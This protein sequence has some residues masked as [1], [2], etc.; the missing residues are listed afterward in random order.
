MPTDHR[1]ALA[2]IR[3]FPQLIA[4]LRDEMGWP[5]KQDSFDE[6]DE[7]F[8]EYT[9]EELGI[10]VQNAA[11]I[12]EIK[13][14]RPLSTHQPWGVFFV[15]FEPKRL[16]VVALRRILSRVALKKRAS[17]NSAERAAWSTD[18]LLFISNY[19]EGESRQICF[20]HFSQNEEKQDLPILKVLGWDNLDSP[21]HL[22]HVAELLTN[23]LSW[24]DDEENESGWR[25]QWHSAFTLVHREVINTSKALSVELA[26]LARN[27]RNSI[28]TV[29]S[30]ESENGPVSKLMAAF[31]EALVHDLDEDGFA[32]MYAQTIAYGLLSARIANPSGDTSDALATAMPVTNPFLKELMAT[33]LEVGGRKGKAGPGPGIDF[34]ELGVSDVI[35]LLD[36]ANMEAVLRDFGDRTPQEDPVIHFFEGFLRE[37]DKKIRKDRGVFYTPRPVVSFIVHSVDELLR[38]EFGLE[39]GLADTTTWGEMAGRI[40]DLEIPEGATATQAFVQVLDP[41][42]G[43]GTFLVEVID[44]IHKTMTVKWQDERQGKKMM[45]KLWN[46]YV[47]KHLLPRLHGYELMMAPYT[48]AHMKIGLKLYETGY[49]FESD[50]RARVYL[51]NALEPAQDFSGRLAFAI[52]ALA[53]EAKAVNAI[54]R[55]QRFTVVIGNPPYSIRSSNL[56]SQ[57]RSLVE[58]FKEIGGAGIR[59]KGAL[60]LEKNLN[61][62]Y[63]K[64]FGLALQLLCEGSL[65]IVSF[66]SNHGFIDNRTFRGFRWNL[67]NNFSR[68]QIVDLHG[69]SKRREMVPAG[70]MNE[71]VFDIQQGV[72][73]SALV[74]TGPG[75]S[76]GCAEIRN[77]WGTRTEKYESLLSKGAN[78]EMAS[79]VEP[80]FS[81]EIVDEALRAEFLKFDSLGE[82]MPVNSTGIKT[83]R[84]AFVIDFDRE[85]LRRRIEEFRGKATDKDIADE[86]GLKDTY[87]WKLSKSR[88]R[89]RTRTDWKQNFQLCLYRPFDHR[90]IYYSSD[91]V[92]LPRSECMRHLAGGANLALLATRQVTSSQFTHALASRLVSEMKTCSHDRGTNCFPLYLQATEGE[93]YASPEPNFSVEFLG[94]LAVT[95]ELESPSSGNITEGVSAVQ[96]FQYIYAVLYSPSYRTR[97]GDF[98]KTEFP[99]LPLPAGN[100]VFQSLAS[101]GEQLVALHLMESERLERHITSISSSGAFQVEK[102]SYSDETVW[103]DKAK[104]RGFKGVPKEVWNFHIGGYQV[105][106]KWLKDRQAKGGNNP[107]PG[108][109]LTEE[110]IEHYQKIVVALSE[111]IRIM[112]EI[113]EIIEAHGGWPN[114]FM[115]GDGEESNAET[116]GLGGASIAAEAALP[117]GDEEE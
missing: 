113:D 110:D 28:N 3:A 84:D 97:Y 76:T 71:N 38:T 109:V 12:Q 2:K 57:A 20:A 14:L 64:F 18:D 73:I 51:T 41:A 58:R 65:G 70:Q 35:A 48:I 104:T 89:M 60:Q 16:P 78:Y 112:A 6:D 61:D 30:I 79:C 56:T 74:R 83:H 53:H 39:D 72:A 11:K 62:D 50:E 100:S 25:M 43:T 68:I 54:K 93:L 5:I 82:V 117:Y 49:R 116:T 88:K 1:T 107:H 69:N 22:D 102:V 111:T 37:Y 75:S 32:D 8:Y 99:R 7:L 26:G 95:L 15:K 86:F 52:P 105:C 67:L 87:G 36:A 24:P 103:I 42:T 63:V 33:F 77:E 91:L 114:A 13:R 19:G 23:Q 21:L 31:K 66:I 34:D 45:E 81:F 96:V 10:D 101:C 85:P 40:D 108:R 29:L 47:P 55:D 80:S 92:E 106:N 46:A 9:P 98:L 17:A 115:V 59:E 4:Y 90:H 44:I 27:I 94:R